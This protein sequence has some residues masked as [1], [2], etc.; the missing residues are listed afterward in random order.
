[1]KS[2]KVFQNRSNFLKLKIFLNIPILLF[3]VACN[4]D[5]IAIIHDTIKDTGHIEFQNPMAE[6]GTG[7]LVGGTPSHLMMVAPPEA[8]FPKNIPGL[9][10]IDSTAVPQKHI[11]QRF[12]GELKADLLDVLGNGSV[13]IGAGIEWDNANEIQLEMEGVEVE[14][15]NSIV[16]SRYFRGELI[17]PDGLK[18]KMPSDCAEYLQYTGF[19]IQ[20]I[21]VNK[22]KF[23]FYNKKGTAFHINPKLIG[24]YIDIGLGI[25]Y[26]VENHTK[27][28]IDTPK[29]MG[30]VLGRFRPEYDGIILYRA[31][32]TKNDKF[33]FESIDIFNGTNAFTI[34]EY[35][36][37]EEPRDIFEDVYLD[38]E[39][40]DASSTFD[41]ES[42]SGFD[43][44]ITKED[45]NTYDDYEEEEDD[46]DWWW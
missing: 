9:R 1:M 41:G 19:I 21:K 6:A 28:V 10:V 45:V 20:A 39:T 32:T 7:T 8:C 25:D 14:Y 13:G 22:L 11:K 30:Y 26:H 40:I 34:A 35:R 44:N 29:Y 5:P 4:P 23:T 37:W 27:L 12:S 16:L 18:Y 38:H 33:V 3:L 24:M 46:D 15:F 36:N 31:S 2:Q 17:G 42:D 43:L